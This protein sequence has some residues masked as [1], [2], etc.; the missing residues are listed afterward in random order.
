VLHRLGPKLRAKLCGTHLCV[1]QA[2][3]DLAWD[4]HIL[5]YH[6]GKSFPQVVDVRDLDALCHD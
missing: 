5:V 6:E 2:R 4:G 3:V 1:L